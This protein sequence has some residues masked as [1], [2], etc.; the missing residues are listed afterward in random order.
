MDLRTALFA[1][2]VLIHVASAS[3]IFLQKLCHLYRQKALE[4]DIYTAG[5]LYP[6]NGYRS[7]RNQDLCANGELYSASG[8]K[9][10]QHQLPL[11][12]QRVLQHK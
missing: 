6:A 12:S 1:F 4:T 11:N 2:G 8:L 10:P 9:K 3:T 7:F 5:E